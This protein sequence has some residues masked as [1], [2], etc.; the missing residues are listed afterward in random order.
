MCIVDTYRRKAYIII[1]EDL[2]VNKNYGLRQKRGIQR[3]YWASEEKPQITGQG[4]T[5]GC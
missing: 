2:N 4:L 5:S 1:P 3:I